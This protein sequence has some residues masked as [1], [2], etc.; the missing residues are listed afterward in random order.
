MIERLI[1]NWLIST[2]ERGYEVP[3]CQLLT[4]QG[5]RLLHLSS[6]GP[7]EQGKDI[8]TV[9]PDGVTCAYQLKGGD[10]KLGEW[11]QIRPEID[12]LIEI[13]I[14]HPSLPHDQLQHRVYLVTNGLLADTVR[15]EI[16]DRNRRNARRGLPE[17]NVILKGDLLKDFVG[18]HGRFLPTELE[19]FRRFLELYLFDGAALLPEK[20]FSEFL[21]SVLPFGEETPK[22]LDTERALASATVLTGYVLSA[23]NEKRNSLSLVNGWVMLAAHVLGIAEGIV[24][25]TENS[26]VTPLRSVVSALQVSQ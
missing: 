5:H 2:N 7:Q 16:D 22:K 23:Y 18:I 24:N 6:H 14:H 10:I 25:L 9:A 19:D 15:R 20:Q 21:M 13:P 8:I 1:E 3:F 4:A 17:L 12:E 11:R 26:R